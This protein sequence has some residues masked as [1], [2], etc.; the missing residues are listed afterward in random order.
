MIVFS[1]APASASVSASG[2]DRRHALADRHVDG[3]EVGV[4]VVDDRVDRDRGLA[5]L[6]VADDQ[7]ALA[8]ADRDHRVDR[9]EAGLHRLGDRLAL[10]DAG[11]LE[12]GRARL[13]RLDVALAVER[14]AERVDDAAEQGLADRDLEQLAGALDGVALDDLAPSRRTARRRRCRTRG[15]ARGR[16]RRAAARASRSDMQL[17]RP[18]TRAMPSRDRQD[19]ADLGQVGLAVVE[20][21][22]AALEDGGDL[23][24]LDLHVCQCLRKLR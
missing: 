12:L 5:G 2:D 9:L 13:G 19:G 3:D 20:A 15:S 21:L 6:A 18:W 7:L 16:S 8:A 10:D 22:D 1:S 11:R 23:V 17:S 24:G 4:L 14:V